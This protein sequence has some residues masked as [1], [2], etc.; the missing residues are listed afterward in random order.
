[1]ISVALIV[2][3]LTFTIGL[4]GAVAVRRVG[5]LRLRLAG[6]ALVATIAP[7]IGIVASGTIMFASG[8]DLLVAGVAAAASTA[9]LFGA[10]LVARSV[11][12]PLDALRAAAAEM[13]AGTLTARAP[14][15]GPTELRTLATDFNRMA[16]DIEA[17]F[18]ARRQLVAW[19]SHDLRT[20][21][22]ALQAMLEAVEDGVSDADHYLPRMRDQVD[23]L[24]R[25]IDDLFELA[26]IDA[27]AVALDLRPTP[28]SS[29]VGSCTR[30][31]EPEAARRRIEL[32]PATDPACPTVRCAP[33]KVERVLGNLVANALR[34]TPDGGVITIAAAPP[35]T[36][37]GYVTISVADTGPGFAPDAE[38]RLF[39]PFYRGDASRG[40]GGA[41]LGLAIARG[42]VEAHGGRIWAAN[43]A[44]NGAELA[45]TLPA[46]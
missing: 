28:V 35:T 34:H 31:F 26:L 29:L 41:G 4:V 9:A 16:S 22:A 42:L 17:L 21:L 23:S 7:V 44:P 46:G 33:D 45:F 36:P 38:Q 18:D 27:G 43:H 39:D 5:S 2:A 13:G 15:E 32:R 20:P 1:M 12:V 24:A 11:L 6:L 3:L 19:A 8:H 40:G 14:I 30:R 37:T 10:A 25:I